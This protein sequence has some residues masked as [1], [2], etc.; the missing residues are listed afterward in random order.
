MDR[1]CVWETAPPQSPPYLCPSSQAGATL[2]QEQKQALRKPSCRQ[3]EHSSTH[4]F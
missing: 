4:W 3:V 2:K 1:T